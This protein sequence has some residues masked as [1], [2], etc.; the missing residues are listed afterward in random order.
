MRR[1]LDNPHHYAGAIV[2]RV[3]VNVATI[4][5]S[6][7]VL[8]ESNALAVTPYGRIMT[9]YVREDI[10]AAAFL[11]LACALLWRVVAQC[12]PHPLG[13]VGYLAI[14]A[15][16]AFVDVVLLLVQR[17]L[18]PTSISWVTAGCV[19]ALWAFIANPKRG[20]RDVRCR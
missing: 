15:L 2:A 14:L 6:V 10:W 17:P 7:V 1:L 12:K 8:A 20:G 13:A 19:A 16:W 4:I 3:I 5:W 9:A 11:A 18:Y